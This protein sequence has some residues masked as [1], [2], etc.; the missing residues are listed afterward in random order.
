[1]GNDFHNDSFWIVVVKIVVVC[2]GLKD[3]D[4]LKD[5]DQ[6]DKHHVP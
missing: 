5:Y 1:M 3:Y 4:R 6:N 2:E